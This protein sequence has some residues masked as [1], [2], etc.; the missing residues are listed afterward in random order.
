MRIDNDIISFITLKLHCFLCMEDPFKCFS[1]QSS[2]EATVH[3]RVT[4]R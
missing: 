1:N 2:N 3:D 4:Q